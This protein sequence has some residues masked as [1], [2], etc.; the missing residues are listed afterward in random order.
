[1]I[2]YEFR[3]EGKDIEIKKPVGGRWYVII[4][5]M[6]V[7]QGIARERDARRISKQ[8]AREAAR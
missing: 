7:A 2:T 1:M 8:R 6:C 4:N 3:Y 5:G